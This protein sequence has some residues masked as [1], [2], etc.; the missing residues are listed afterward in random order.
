M[1]KA[2]LN[3]RGVITVYCEILL[4]GDFQWHWEFCDL[5]L[6]IC[7]ERKRKGLLVL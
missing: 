1:G 7:V 5:F 6:S 4:L 3:W 2:M